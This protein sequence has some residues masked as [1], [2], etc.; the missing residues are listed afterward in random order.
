[1]E[2]KEAIERV[3]EAVGEEVERLSE[4]QEDVAEKLEEAW[5]LIVK[6]VRQIEKERGSL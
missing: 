3:E 5:N 6:W 4:D 1:M 2:M